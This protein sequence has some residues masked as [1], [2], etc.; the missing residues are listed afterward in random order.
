M[1]QTFA[2]AGSCWV[3]ITGFS[4]DLLDGRSP[5]SGVFFHS[6]TVGQSRHSFIYPL[7][8][9]IFL[10]ATA[11]D[12]FSESPQICL[13]AD[14]QMLAGHFLQQWVVQMQHRVPVEVVCFPSSTWDV[15]RGMRDF[16]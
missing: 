4:S 1:S 6:L 5:F 3:I 15:T 13:E 14:P 16:C 7:V 12:A 9:F 8:T 11:L 10:I 2:P